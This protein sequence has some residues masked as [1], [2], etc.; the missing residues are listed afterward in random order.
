MLRPFARGF[1]LVVSIMQRYKYNW[2]M[3]RHLKPGSIA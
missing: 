3:Q 1:T 2:V